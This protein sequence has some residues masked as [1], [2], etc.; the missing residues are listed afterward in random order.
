MNLEIIAE[1]AQG[2]EGNFAQ[3]KL[4]LKA[5]AS[6][7]ADAAKFQLVY[8]DELATPD[9]K[10]YDLFRSLEMKDS[11]WQELAEYAK[12]LKIQ[13]Y[14]DIFGATSLKLSEKI[15]INGIKLHGTDIANMGLLHEIANSSIN[16][17]LLGAGGAHLS[18]IENALHILEKKHVIIILG[19]QG[20]PTSNET[21]QIE[22]VEILKSYLDGKYT[23]FTLGFADHADP[24]SPLRY[25]LAATAI[26]SGA[27]II[28]KHLTL[29]QVM[30]MEDYESALNPD[31]FSEFTHVLRECYLS[32]GIANKEEDFGMSESEK[33]YRLMIRRHVVSSKDMPVGTLLSPSDL[34]LKRTSSVD[35]ITDLN[36]VYNKTLL[37]NVFVNAALSSNDFK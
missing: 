2:F 28:E 31:E 22:R 34:V 33:K 17:I 27:R 12:E 8:A 36:S 13:L 3:A 37:R 10:Y 16:K 23:N 32:L 24:S 1:L 21:N 15:G 6:S 18:E 4:L 11:D 29:G 30:K 7:G 20:Y 9:Y 14:L 19:F 5:A 35:F 25:A 26:G